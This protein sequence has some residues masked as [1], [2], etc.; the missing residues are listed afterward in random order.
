M[1][2][3]DCVIKRSQDG[4]W[5]H[6]TA[7]GYKVRMNEE[8]LAVLGSMA[9]RLSASEMTEKER[10]IYDKLSQKGIAAADTGREEDR[11]LIIKEKS[12][13]ELVELEFSG[14]C[15]LRCSH[16][17]SA[18]SQKDM[19]AETL[20]KVFAGIDALDPV[21]LI[22]NGGEPLLNPLLPEALEKARARHLRV[23]IMTNAML[24]SGGIAGMLKQYGVAKA[25][26]SLDFF[27]ENHNAIRGSG[28]FKK[29][30][31][32]I[33]LLISR[34]VPVFV[35]AM[36]RENVF[37][38]LEEFKNFCL[39]ELGV[40]GIRFSSIMPIGKAKDSPVAPGLSAARL[41]E[42]F[43]KGLISSDHENE[44]VL[45]KL[46]GSRNFYCKAGVGEC[47]VS[48][49]GKVYA[50]HYFQNI[51]ETMGDLAVKP[52]EAIYRE[53]PE[54]G[55]IAVDLDWD[56]LKKCKAC[57]HFAKCMGGCRARAKL[58]SGGWYAPDGYSCDMYGVPE[59]K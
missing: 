48:A 16:C 35:T 27:E 32:G 45:S 10:S 29:T 22:I 37:G 54:S 53:Y 46:T 49:E 38:R 55:A 33:K 28:A 26:V 59:N 34:K 39:G 14:R 15:N 57:G 56:K 44:G 30:V 42:L 25:V 47:F 51:G 8:A 12:R 6:H 24:V 17:F 4:I 58:L 11:R 2:I 40:S 43:N 5:L 50:C 7:S 9:S 1:L 21:N 31:S 13:L 52:L 18:L 20:E 36:V 3:K 19:G 41:K 23:G